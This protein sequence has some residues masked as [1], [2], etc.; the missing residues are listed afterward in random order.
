MSTAKSDEY[1]ARILSELERVSETSRS[2]HVWQVCP[3]EFLCPQSVPLR[4][5]CDTAVSP[6]GDRRTRL[7]RRRSTWKSSLPDFG[8]LR[9]KTRHGH[10]LW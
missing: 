10:P 8:A 2:D 5:V 3:L 9:G 7:G 4:L 1:N 6:L